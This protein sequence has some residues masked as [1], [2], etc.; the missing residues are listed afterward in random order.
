MHEVQSFPICTV[1]APKAY[2]V[3]NRTCTV[4]WLSSKP[5]GTDPVIYSLQLSRLRDQEYKQV[6]SVTGLS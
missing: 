3:S 1:S 6:C 4:E 2:D 5:M